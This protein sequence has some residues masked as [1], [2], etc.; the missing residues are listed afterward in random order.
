MYRLTLI[1]TRYT[2]S[3][4]LNIAFRCSLH[5]R[6]QPHIQ[7]IFFN[8]AKESSKWV[9][10][11]TNLSLSVNQYS[12]QWPTKL[13]GVAKFFVVSWVQWDASEITSLS[14]ED[15]GPVCIN[16]SRLRLSRSTKM[17]FISICQYK[18]RLH[19]CIFLVKKK[20]NKR[21]D[22]FGVNIFCQ[23]YLQRRVILR[24]R[25]KAYWVF[26]RGHPRQ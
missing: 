19:P 12:V 13:G 23:E 8:W 24:L 7:A 10:G 3:Y 2:Y 11:F 9:M 21:N 14:K 6:L 5:N 17:S 4:V 18:W 1:V 20:R 22:N 15:E 26:A 25:L 16:Q